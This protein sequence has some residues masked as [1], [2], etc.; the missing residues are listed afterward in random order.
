MKLSLLEVAGLHNYKYFTCYAY[1]V[2]IGG[3][4]KPKSPDKDDESGKGR[5][6]RVM[7]NVS[8]QGPAKRVRPE[9]TAAEALQELSTAIAKFIPSAT[10]LEA[11]GELRRDKEVDRK[12]REWHAKRDLATKQGSVAAVALKGT[13]MCLYRATHNR[14]SSR[15]DQHS[16][17]RLF[18]D[19]GPEFSSDNAGDGPCCIDFVANCLNHTLVLISGLFCCGSVTV[20]IPLIDNTPSSNSSSINPL[21]VYIGK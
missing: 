7:L 1:R 21:Q 11:I 2:F 17:K 14:L 18:E 20:E 9:K 13:N 5:N 6:K 15:D 4:P 16:V 12:R 19:F 10:D 8:D 3:S